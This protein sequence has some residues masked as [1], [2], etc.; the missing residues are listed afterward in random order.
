MY[1]EEY[2][3]YDEEADSIAFIISEDENGNA[4]LRAPLPTVSFEMSEDELIRFLVALKNNDETAKIID[5]KPIGFEH[6][7]D[8]ETFLEKLQACVQAEENKRT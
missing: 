3:D 6:V 8:T 4:V 7:G 2:D 5:G 1:N